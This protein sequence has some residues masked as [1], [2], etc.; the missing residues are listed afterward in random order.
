MIRTGVMAG[1]VEKTP[2]EV[3]FQMTE[4]IKQVAAAHPHQTMEQTLAQ[5]RKT[6]PPEH[7]ALHCL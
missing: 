2:E 3:A 1:G 5:Q 4:A 6:R 7:H